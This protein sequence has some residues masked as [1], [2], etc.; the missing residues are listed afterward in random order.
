MLGAESLLLIRLVELSEGLALS[1][2]GAVFLTLLTLRYSSD[3]GAMIGSEVSL[4]GS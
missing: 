4:G 3:L 1:T 2:V